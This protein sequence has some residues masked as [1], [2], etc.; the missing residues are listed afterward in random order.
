MVFWIL[1]SVARS[2]DALERIPRRVER[3]GQRASEK[4]Q[5]LRRLVQDHQPAVL[6]ERT[7]DRKQRPFALR[8]VRAFALD[9][10]VQREPVLGGARSQ[11]GLLDGRAAMCVALDEVRA[12]QRVPQLRVVVQRER[13]QIGADGA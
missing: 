6:H 12:A 10:R 4:P 2:T 1:L 3:A 11:V 9:D 13:V 8:Q 7:R 5:H